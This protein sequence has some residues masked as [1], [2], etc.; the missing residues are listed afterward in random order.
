[1]IAEPDSHSSPW[2][3]VQTTVEHLKDARQIARGLVE[4]RLAACVQIQAEIESIY[5]WNG[6]IE[7]GREWSLVAKSHVRLWSDLATWSDENHPYECP[8]LIAL[9]LVRVAP[10][11]ESWLNDQLLD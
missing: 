2:I 1:M 8:Q 11:F 6:Q 9:P 5:R 3:H 4:T 10:S 7:Q